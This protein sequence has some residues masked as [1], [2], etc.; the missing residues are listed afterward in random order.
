VDWSAGQYERTAAQ[1]L[2]AARATVEQAAPSAGERAL[3]L[4]CGT[5]NAALLA[6][7]RGARVTG[8]DPAE[9][10]LGVAGE[11]AS[12]RGL[13]VDLVRAEAGSLPLEDES[14]EL[15]MSVFGVIFAPDARAAAAEIARVTTPE[16][17]IV[18]AAWIPGGALFDVMRLRR[19]AI[20]S[21]TGAPP[22]APPFGWHDADALGGLFAAHGFSLEMH[23][24]SLAFIG[25]SP[26]QFAKAEFRDHP[27]WIQARSALEPRQWEAL[28][29]R[30]V[31]TLELAN[32]DPAG[33]QITS[34]YILATLRR[35]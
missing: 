9:R 14:T 30:A 11:R 3:D 27:M 16:A 19:E 28:R 6:A 12:A 21:A 13:D 1:L 22:G 24:K 7:E 5:G 31:G 8:V 10:L 34:R 32:E 20:A 17:R 18:L 33:F 35:G 4:G 29:E 25:T 23:E 26:E 2:P 15:V